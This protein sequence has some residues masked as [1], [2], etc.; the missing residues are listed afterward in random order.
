MS[1]EQKSVWSRTCYPLAAIA[2]GAGL[3]LVAPSSFASAKGVTELTSCSFASLDT[4][5]SGGG[6]IDYEQN[7]NGGSEVQFPTEIIFKGTVDIEANGFGVTFYG[8]ATRLFDLRGGSLTISGVRFGRRRGDRTVRGP[9]LRRAR[10][11]TPARPVH[12]RRTQTEDRPA[13]ARPGRTATTARLLHFRQP[14]RPKPRVGRCSS[15]RV[16]P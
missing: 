6:T 3:A 10:P 12:R 16:A 2:L 11:A 8:S 4:A 15:R 5:I 1:R 7:C 9:R 13:R 14:P